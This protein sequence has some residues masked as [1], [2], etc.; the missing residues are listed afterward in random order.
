MPRCSSSAPIRRSAARSS[1]LLVSLAAR[2]RDLFVVIAKADRVSAA[3]LAEARAFTERTLAEALPGHRVR[4]L[5]VSATEVLG[6]DLPT[7]DWSRLVE[8]LEAL[9]ERDGASLVERART[10]ETRRLEASIRDYLDE[11]EGALRRPVAETEQRVAALTRSA[12][13]AE[14]ALADLRQLFDARQAQIAREM[15][16][17]RM[18]FIATARASIRAELSERVEQAS[19]A[20]RRR[21]GMELAQ[22]AT[23][24][25]VQAWREQLTPRV[26][27]QFSTAAETFLAGSNAI[28]ARVRAANGAATPAAEGVVD[29]RLGARS[30]YCFH[31]FMTEASPSPW[32]R[33]RDR[34]RGEPGRLAAAVR[35]GQTFADRLVE[36]NASRAAHD[37]VDRIVETRRGLE[38]ALHRAHGA[39]AIASELQRLARLRSELEAVATP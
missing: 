2:V 30:R 12:I 35:A 14:R 15:D 16:A 24:L 28:A 23:E 4:I 5:Q 26:E 36:V 34:L 6:A 39:S 17:E 32:S 1:R 11:L 19:P 22:Q 7:R 25:R 8:A 9:A 20:S 27:Q 10:R 21:R 33:L 38:A 29:T 3:D 13:D 31:R 37:L 18:A